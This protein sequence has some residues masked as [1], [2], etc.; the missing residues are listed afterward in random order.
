MPTP[1]KGI[2]PARGE[3]IKKRDERKTL[4]H[5]TTPGI[6][7]NLAGKANRDDSSPAPCIPSESNTVDATGALISRVQ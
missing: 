1:A 7:A 5:D 4:I 2:S 6:Q 3:I